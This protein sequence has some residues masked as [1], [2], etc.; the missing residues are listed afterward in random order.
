ML[1]TDQALE[2]LKADG[3][4]ENIQMVRRWIR[5]GEL[6]AKAPAKRKDG[7]LISEAD[8]AAFIEKKRKKPK[9]TAEEYEAE[10]QEL[11]EELKRV[12]NENAAL[13]SKVEYLKEVERGLNVDRNQ[14]I[15]QLEQMEKKRNEASGVNWKRKYDQLLKKS[16][17]TLDRAIRAEQEIEFLR[18]NLAELKN[19]KAVQPAGDCPR[20]TRG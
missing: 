8:L 16:R 10:I 17:E 7:Y 12:Q 3:I 5:N 18:K 20:K 1:T 14:L 9:K 6:V 19:E 4:T 13:A 11:R 15:E 2:R